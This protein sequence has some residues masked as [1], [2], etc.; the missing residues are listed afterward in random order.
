MIIASLVLSF[1]HSRYRFQSP[2]NFSWKRFECVFKPPYRRKYFGNLSLKPA[3]ILSPYRLL[4]VLVSKTC[5]ANENIFARNMT[6]GQ[7]IIFAPRHTGSFV[8]FQPRVVNFF[9][10]P[11]QSRWWTVSTTRMITYSQVI[12]SDNNVCK[13]NF[14]SPIASYCCLLILFHCA[15]MMSWIWEPLCS[16]RSPEIYAGSTCGHP[17]KK[18]LD[19]ARRFDTYNV[20][21][22]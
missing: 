14:S 12:L 15:I 13:G 18:M 21:G 3:K 10:L 17:W 5:H 1:H 11:I 22:H 8:F 7:L 2:A 9:I 6:Q 16:S 20:R 19:F 4:D